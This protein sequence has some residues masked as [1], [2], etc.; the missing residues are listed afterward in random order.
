MEHEQICVTQ[1]P[2]GRIRGLQRDDV[3]VFKGIRYATAE[4]FRPPSLVTEW[5]GEI[6]ATS[7]TAQAPQLF[8]L[9]E[10]ALGASSIPA[11]ED[12]L[13]L[14]VFTPGCDDRRR[15]VMVW[16][17]GGAFTTGGGAM[18][19]YDGSQLCRLGDIVVVTINYRLGALGFSGRTNAG[20]RDQVA[21]LEW[22]HRGIE[23]FG[24]DPGN[25]TI[26]G[27]SAGGS[28]VVALMAVPSAEGLFHGAFAMSPSIAQLRSGERADEALE[29]YLG[30][31]GVQSIDDLRDLP[32]DPLL[33]AQA[34]ILRNVSAGFTGFSPCTDGHFVPRPILEA[35]A[36][37]PVPLVVGTTRDEMNLFSAF[38][39][40]MAQLSDADALEHFG[41]IFGEGASVALELY[42]RA[43]PGAT[44]GQLVSALQTDHIFRVPAQR[45]AEARVRHDVPTWM[46]WFAWA[47]PAFGGILG[48]CH[49]VDIPF[50][51]HNLARP[52]VEQFT[53]AG[54][55]RE[56]VADTYS[57]AVLALTREGKPGW[58]QYDL[59]SRATL[60]IDI[61]SELLA[62]P[63]RDLRVLWA[64]TA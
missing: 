39:P 12:C 40:N 44:N 14:N 57:A 32:I 41:R 24:G 52:G 62:D 45:L 6:D 30:H 61:D 43:R 21:A 42:R 3:S 27:E 48:A 1:T 5:D 8:G 59:G 4:R 33:G 10:K 26:V 54:P 29:E 53:G 13:S 51:F 23:A 36:A 58:P 25:V 46:Y 9:L 20:L 18:P 7:Y 31:V 15:P 34:L 64:A 55:G 16:I 38:N 17:H 35:A 49:A 37:N 63:E 2:F 19:W 22:V 60:R 56:A 50:A 11:A 28:S 47:T